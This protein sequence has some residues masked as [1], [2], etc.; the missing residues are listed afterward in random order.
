VVDCLDKCPGTPAGTKVEANGCPPAAEQGAIIFRNILFNFNKADLIADSFSVLDQVIEY[1][2]ANPGI[3]MEI[4]GHTDN[5]GT[6]GYNLNLSRR[7]AES[8][9]TY[10]VEKGIPPER[11]EVKGFGLSKPTAPNDTGENRARNRRVELKPM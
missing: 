11:L 7:R 9:R 6:Q 3:S 10:L 4:Q 2:K 8:V 1:L 5:I